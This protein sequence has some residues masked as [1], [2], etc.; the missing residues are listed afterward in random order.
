MRRP[1]LNTVMQYVRHL[2]GPPEAATLTDRELIQAFVSRR[3]EAAFAA[4][5]HRHGA[6]VWG[7]CRR[8]L[9]TAQDAEDA[10]QAVFLVLARKAPSV[11]WR[12]DVSN[13]LYDVSVR[14]ACKA[15]VLA[16]RRRVC[17][18]K[19]HS[20]P[21]P[22]TANER[23]ADLRSHLD[24]EMGRLPAKYRQPLVLHYLEGKSYSEIAVQ[25]GLPEGTVSSRLAR[26][27]EM[28]RRRL[29]RRDRTPSVVGF[30]ALLTQAF[31]HTPLPALLAEGTIRGV[32]LIAT[33]Q[34]AGTYISVTAVSLAHG[35][36]KAMFLAKLKLAAGFFVAL[37]LV[38]TGAGVGSYVAMA[39]PGGDANHPGPRVPAADAAQDN[40][41][42]TLLREENERLRAELRKLQD[43]AGAARPRR[44]LYQGKP[45]DYWLEQLQ[46]R[47]PEYREL[48]FKALAGIAEVDHS[49]FWVI[50]RSLGDKA[51]EVR[52]TAVVGFR[53]IGAV[54][55]PFLSQAARDRDKE[56]RIL[57]LRGLSST[58][59]SEAIPVLIPALK[60]P[61]RDI[62]RE[63]AQSL[64]PY[65]DA[66]AVRQALAGVLGDEDAAVRLAATRV[67]RSTWT[68]GS[69]PDIRDAMVRALRDPD[70]RVRWEAAHALSRMGLDARPAIPALTAALKDKDSRIRLLAG[71]TLLNLEHEI[72]IRGSKRG[73]GAANPERSR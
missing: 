21:V 10:F 19:A 45:A 57:A 5:V 55:L 23:M 26:G 39:A 42:V 72:S 25:L 35:V 24:E 54:A 62:R 38:G 3:D 15:R 70:V 8:V 59:L 48:A 14:T 52:A 31:S 58:G 69:L 6:L 43:V 63:G 18:R 12:S 20:M 49:L 47:D 29:E 65:I 1:A 61:D 71:T 16:A 60:D 41:E 13:W 44:V 50:L 4:L 64:L 56:T 34:G 28:L 40:P 33:G 66:P 2:A 36:L 11:S 17:E 37:T 27:R 22:E 67:L 53:Q 7:V 51:P 30:P 73:A 68:P 46:D 32:V 9:A